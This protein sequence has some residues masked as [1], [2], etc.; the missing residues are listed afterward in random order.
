MRKIVHS[1]Y[2]G[3]TASTLGC[4]SLRKRSSL[5][6]EGERGGEK[7]GGGVV[8]FIHVGNYINLLQNCL[9]GVEEK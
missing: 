4:S 9:V 6:C 7:G 8:Q 3:I 5:V 1:F 2:I